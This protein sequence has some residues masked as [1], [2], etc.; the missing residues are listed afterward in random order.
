MA[1][2]WNVIHIDGHD[3]I[4]MDKV[5]SN[6]RKNQEKPTLIVAKTAFA[7]G[8]L[9]QTSI[10]DHKNS[11]TEEELIETKRQL[12]LSLMP[13]YVPDEIYSYFAK[14][15]LVNEERYTLW[16]TQLNL[17]KQNNAEIDLF[18]SLLS[19]MPSIETLIN[20]LQATTNYNEYS[21]G[22]CIEKN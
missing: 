3:V 11:L 15:A 4:E 13:F 21:L 18:F 2:N 5:F 20:E 19:K 17:I 9:K 14:V 1:C 16:L 22:T 10:S 7:K 12:G 6:L 8:L